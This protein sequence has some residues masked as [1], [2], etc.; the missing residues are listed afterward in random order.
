MNLALVSQDLSALD[1]TKIVWGC[2]GVR[3]FMLNCCK[4]NIVSKLCGS[5]APFVVAAGGAFGE[6]TLTLLKE[7]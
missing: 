6:K 3:I 7:C 2:W 5:A 1:S 4:N